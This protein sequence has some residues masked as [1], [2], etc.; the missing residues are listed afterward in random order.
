MQNFRAFVSFADKR[1]FYET[2]VVPPQW[3]QND[4]Y[5]DAIDAA[6]NLRN[7][8]FKR[9]EAKKMWRFDVVATVDSATANALKVWQLYS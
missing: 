1:P 9:A 7:E 2:P 6:H 3:W 8:V 4:K 5:N